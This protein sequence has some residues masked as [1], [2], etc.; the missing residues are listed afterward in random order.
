MTTGARLGR[1]I[2]LRIAAVA[3][4]LAAVL[5]AL[6]AAAQRRAVLQLDWT[7]NT[8]HTGIYVAL[9]KGWYE[10]AG[11]DLQ[12]VVPGTD[13]NA[14][15]LVAAGRAQFGIS[16]QEHMT[17]ARTEGL[18][19]VSVAAIIQH[20]TSGFASIGKGIHS[21]ADFAGKRFGGW[22]MPMER[23]ILQA[24]MARDGADV[25][26]VQ[27]V[28]LP[29]GVDLVTML[30]RD[31]DFTWI[32]YG[33]QGI[34]AELRGV[35]LDV[36]MMD[37]YFDAV[38]DYYTPVLVTSEALIASDPELVRAV[39]EATARGYVY[40]AEHPDE[41]AEIL[42]KYAPENDPELVRA[43]QRWLSPR[44]I[45]DAPY[46]GYQSLEVWQAFGDWMYDHGL[47]REPFDAAAAFTNDFLPK[48]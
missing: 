11:V 4:V 23:A 20:N 41:A 36:V 8:N 12:V 38:P 16:F 31:I 40:A 19:V 43:S 24:M 39:V 46:F 44:Y 27:F 34:E 18:P 22:G 13:P 48:P 37:Q 32:Y 1:R 35:E 7:P 15:T 14:L 9:D 2:P 26:D 25:D 33:W 45:D 42:L 21:A 10:E 3:A 6:P 30:T 47:I 29:G 17:S 5:A 28:V